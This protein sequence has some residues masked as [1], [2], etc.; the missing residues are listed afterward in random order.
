LELL[1]ANDDDDGGLLKDCGRSGQE[2]FVLPETDLDVVM[3]L[4]GEGDGSYASYWG[5]DKDGA[6][7]CLATDF[8]LLYN[9]DRQ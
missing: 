1:Y 7:V 4:A 3:C 6:V 9:P 2:R 5:L 8:A